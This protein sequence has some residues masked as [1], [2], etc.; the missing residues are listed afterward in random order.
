MKIKLS[1]LSIAVLFLGSLMILCN[2]CKKKS[3]E[4]QDPSSLSDF[5]IISGYPEI[6]KVETSLQEPMV[7][8]V[9]DQFGKIYEGATGIFTV[10]E[11]SI[12]LSDS[13]SDENGEVSVRWTLGP[14]IGKQ[15]ML[16]EFLGRN[17]R[18]WVKGK[19]YVTAA[20]KNITDTDGNIY[21]VEI[22]KDQ[23]WMSENLKVTRYSD[24]TE[25]ALIENDTEWANLTPQDT[26]YCFYNNNASDEGDTYGAL[27]T[28]AAAMKGADSSSENPSGV[29]GV[30]PDGW[31]LPSKAEW[32]ELTEY[33]GGEDIAG[34]KLKESGT[35]QW[36]SPNTG[37]DNESGFTGLP[38]GGRSNL[39]GGFYNS[40][41]NIGCWWSASEE[42]GNSVQFNL[43]YD[44]AYAD[45]SNF[46]VKSCGVSVRCIMDMP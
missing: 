40:L 46:S 5:R 34:G 30:C 33:L 39:D 41:G 44:E 28:W 18:G 36:N 13:I 23:A 17:G 43:Y 25:I 32:E 3:P 9:T 7:F 8:K 45:I 10:T 12:S 19:E 21:N 26:A 2:S 16:V 6:A 20:P 4:N 29:Q 35:A 15:T 11:G 31:H 37:A 38:G 42:E 27:Y 14:T 1:I 24:E 22:I